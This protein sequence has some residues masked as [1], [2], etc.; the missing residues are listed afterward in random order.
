MSHVLDCPA[1]SDQGVHDRVVIG[2]AKA[3]ASDKDKD[4]II[5]T[6]KMAKDRLLLGDPGGYWLGIQAKT[7]ATSVMV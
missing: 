1:I 7:L 3:H 5:W 4:L 2:V 6:A